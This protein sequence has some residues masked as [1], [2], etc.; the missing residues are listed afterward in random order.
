[1]DK[2]K[3][4][5]LKRKF[6]LTLMVFIF[7]LGCHKNDLEQAREYSRQSEEYYR[8]SAGK[9]KKLIS[10]GGNQDVLYFELGQLYYDHGE[11]QQAV[12]EL[13]KVKNIKAQKL[14]AFSYYKLGNYTDALE[15]FNQQ[16]LKEDEFLYYKAMT[17]EKLNLFD[18]ALDIY[19]KIKDGDYSVLV[20]QRVNIIEK[21]V[22]AVNIKD[23]DRE[24]AE[25]LANAPLE[26]QYPQAGALI[27]YC[28]EKVKI[29]TDN[30][31]VSSL[32]YL[33]KILNERGKEEFSE[34][35][36]S[37][38][39]TFEKIEL[40]Y[41]R[42]IKP[43]GTVVEVGSRHM[44]D[45][46]KY[47][48]FPLY[49]N[50]RVFIISF[51]EMT[52]GASIEY[53]LK[54]YRNQLINKKDFVMNYPV[55]SQEPIIAANFAM[56]V[57]KDTKVSIKLLNE[58]YNNF[59][60]ELKPKIEDSDKSLIYKWDF[61]NIPQIMPE[62]NMPDQ[63]E[64]N[65]T[66]ML[67]SFE[68]W[69]EVYDWWWALASDKITADEAIINKVNELIK[70]KL[71]SEEKIKAL[72]NFVIQKIRYVAVEYGQAG[73]EP[74]KAED[75]FR[76]KYG[77]CKD[78]AILLVAM[79]RHAGF[80]AFPVLIP[81][82]E[83]YNLNEDFPSM[84]FNHAIAAV[85]L[86]EKIVF[87]D[88]TAETCAFGDLPPG[89]QNRKVLLLKDTGYEILDTPL[90]PAEHNL[91]K[92]LLSIRINDDETLSA[93]KIVFP[94][95]VYDLSQRYWL[96]FTMPQLIRD[97]LE[98]KIQEISIGAILEDYKI[99][100]LDNLNKPV[101]LSYSFKGP[102][103]FTTAG[104]LRIFPQLTG[105]DSALVSKDKRSYP[106]EFD[107]L[108]IKDTALEVDLPSNYAIKYVPKSFTQDS[109]WM[110]YSVEYKTKDKK[111]FFN[112]R[113]E[114]KKNIVTKNE[115]QEFKSFFEALS[116]KVKQKIVLEKLN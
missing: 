104:K 73:Y 69:Q 72:S 45:V 63:V 90:F 5:F 110:K 13:K 33:V 47:L 20:F 102:E 7:L 44:R 43:D 1:M 107:F 4:P 94:Y 30:T 92:H 74:H 77:D 39:S 53:K 103:Y 58:Q 89:D 18:Q 11:F 105:L 101:V 88:A 32:H 42:T 57:P 68:S 109:P 93:N 21:Q 70:D 71:S 115:Y 65:P 95:G 23:T 81:T 85:A 112:Q 50:V 111:I 49:S 113:V 28:D 98:K 2:S 114:L 41:A 84:F 34:V 61:K 62:A 19:S 91:I 36:I 116:K 87:V 37:Y 10:I 97:Q 24:I 14:L 25:K 40:E 67:S 78:Q 64:I 59:G 17:C 38:D 60:A 79:L 99:E 6:L 27:L 8:Q 35:Q 48:N 75:I 16:E 106:I 29:T 100:N 108:D 3:I 46:S 26:E 52:E 31:E 22:K 86:G 56:E 83:C 55:Q 96:L 15:V 82:K 54:I 80:T 51:P 76:N 12:V 66:I 9:Y